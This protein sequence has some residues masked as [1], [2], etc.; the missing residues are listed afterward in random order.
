MLP[1]ARY[2]CGRVCE[3]GARLQHTQPHGVA[4]TPAGAC[5]SSL[6]ATSQREPDQLSRPSSSCSSFMGG[7]WGTASL[8]CYSPFQSGK[9]LAG[10]LHI[11]GKASPGADGRGRLRSPGSPC[12]YGRRSAGDARWKTPSFREVACT[13][14]HPCQGLCRLLPL[15]HTLDRSSIQPWRLHLLPQKRAFCKAHPSWHFCEWGRHDPILQP[16]SLRHGAAE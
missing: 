16:R 9:A 5:S 11:T 8:G 6:E 4:E 10:M 3:E 14:H 7:C 13:A 1:S 12:L 15:T 2:A